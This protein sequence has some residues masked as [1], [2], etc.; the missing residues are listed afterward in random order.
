MVY[1]NDS[2]RGMSFSW[3]HWTKLPYSRCVLRMDN[4]MYAWERDCCFY[5]G[6]KWL[7]WEYECACTC[8]SES[9]CRGGGQM[10]GQGGLNYFNLKTLQLNLLEERVL[11]H[12]HWPKRFSKLKL[13]LKCLKLCLLYFLCWCFELWTKFVCGKPLE[14][15]FCEADY[16]EIISKAYSLSVQAGSDWLC[17]KPK[18]LLYHNCSRVLCAWKKGNANGWKTPISLLSSVCQGKKTCTTSFRIVPLFI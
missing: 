6:M 12:K 5:D 16:W 18:P 13:G 11:G 14:R 10:P 15:C 3:W 7:G 1:G 4:E 9:G 8:S 17:F 2:P